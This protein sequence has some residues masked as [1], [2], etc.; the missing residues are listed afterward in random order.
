M[1]SGTGTS[2]QPRLGPAWRSTHQGG[3]GFQ[4]PPAAD[5]E[6][7]ETA[8]RRDSNRNSFSVLGADDETSTVKAAGEGSGGAF[9]RAKS[10]PFS[11][12]SDSLRTTG[13]GTSRPSSSALN[14]KTAG[15]GRSLADLAARQGMTRSHS[16][17]AT[18]VSGR[19]PSSGFEEAGSVLGPNSRASSMRNA[20]AMDEKKVIRYTREKLLSMR[21]RP[22]ADSSRP[23]NLVKILDGTPLLSDVPIDPGKF[24]SNIQQICKLSSSFIFLSRTQFV[25]IPSML[26]RFGKRQKSRVEAQVQQERQLVLV[27]HQM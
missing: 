19:R 21:P 17:H 20:V 14:T 13:G 3:R 4:P 9:S 22:G 25:G 18:V 2:S 5:A 1:S 16:T 8:P 11:S 6:S 27:F 15:S 12:R 26:M 7:R 23:E 24:S 10:M